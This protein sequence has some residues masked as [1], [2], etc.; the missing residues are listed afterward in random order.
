VENARL[1][2]EY[3]VISSPIDGRTGHCRSEGERGEGDDVPLVTINQV[4][5]CTSPFLSRRQELANIRKYKETG[6]LRVE[7]SIPQGSGKPPAGSL[8]SSTIK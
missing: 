2:L 5:R 1:Q 4:S 8:T 7:A 6:E 3:T